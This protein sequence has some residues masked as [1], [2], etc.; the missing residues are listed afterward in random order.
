VAFRSHSSRPLGLLA[1]LAPGS[2]CVRNAGLP[3]SDGRR[4]PILRRDPRF[5]G[6]LNS[7]S[8]FRTL[9]WLP[10]RRGCILL[11]VASMLSPVVGGCRTE[12]GFIPVRFGWPVRGGPGAVRW[13][14]GRMVRPLRRG[15][16]RAR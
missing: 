6:M 2:D 4:V 10:S 14:G 7:F 1:P 11:V 8:V 9:L 5:N 3:V 13:T 12:D 15:L 16:G